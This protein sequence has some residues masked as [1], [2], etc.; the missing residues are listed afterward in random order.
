MNNNITTNEI[1]MTLTELSNI[2]S[3]TGYICLGHGIG[4]SGNNDDVVDSIFKEGLRTKDNSLYYTTVVLTTPTPE[5]IENYKEQGLVPPT[6][7]KLEKEL[8]NW[9]HQDSKKIIIARIPCKY[10][11]QSG[12]RSDLDGEMYGAFM[13]EK[14]TKSGKTVNY[15]NTKFIL[16]CY[17]V[18]KQMVRINK[19]FEKEISKE[20]IKR[21]KNG[22]K[23]ALLKTKNRLERMEQNNNLL[24]EQPIQKDSSIT[25]IFMSTKEEIISDF[26]DDI[27]WGISPSDENET[28][29][30][31]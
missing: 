19:S 23:E 2:L 27:D 4:R 29:K 31:K 17:D 16:G 1:Y 18:E 3:E 10:I 7:T 26:G 24:E 11:N 13:I 9:Q 8:N 21:L 22:Y 14:N 25:P 30:T 5:I 20:T 12:N 15:L 6:I 28:K